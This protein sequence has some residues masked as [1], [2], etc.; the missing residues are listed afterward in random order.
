MRCL[1]PFAII[2]SFFIIACST[3]DKEKITINQIQVIGSHNSYKQQIEKPV[4]ELIL[5]RDSNS[6]GLDYAHIPMKDQ[7]DLGLRG[8]EID[9]LHDPK[10]GDIKTLLRFKD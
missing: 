1:Y 6:I 10:G 3:P 9:V 8:L 2:S 4:M 5:A 7:L